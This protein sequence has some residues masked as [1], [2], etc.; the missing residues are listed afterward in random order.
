[1]C[2]HP[3]RFLYQFNIKTISVLKSFSSK[4][5]FRRVTPKLGDRYG[6]AKG[7]TSNEISLL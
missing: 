2:I 3:D 6:W 4:V 5:D 7:I 1:M